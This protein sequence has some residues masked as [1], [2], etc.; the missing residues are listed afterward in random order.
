M[1]LRIK[2]N[3][4]PHR[5]ENGAVWIG[6]A[7]PGEATEITDEAG[8]VWPI[9][10][11]LDGMRS[12]DALVAEVLAEQGPGGETT[13]GEIGEIIDFLIASGWVLDT[14]APVPSEL[15]ERECERYQRNAHFFSAIDLR[16]GSTGYGLQ[17]RLKAA[18]VGVLGLAGWAAPPRPA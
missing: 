17:A 14:A 2:P 1:G 10:R 11:R 4:A 16:P 3:H 9:C 8:V 13:S 5:L 7:L 15:S 18:R 6:P 12:R